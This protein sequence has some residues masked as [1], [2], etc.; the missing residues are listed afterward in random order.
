MLRAYVTEVCAGVDVEQAFEGGEGIAG[1]LVG[2]T[3][4]DHFLRA[5]AGE[6]A[7]FAHEPGGGKQG[8][9]LLAQE[10]LAERFGVDP[11]VLSAPLITTLVDATGLV[12][13][14]S[15]AKTILGL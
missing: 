1:S 13:Y 10:I 8:S 7:G 6:F 12:I 5:D 14:F 4:G 15:I 2:F 9:E 11:T 3:G